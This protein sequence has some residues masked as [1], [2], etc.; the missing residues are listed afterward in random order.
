[1][2]RVVALLAVAALGAATPLGAQQVT[3]RVGGEPTSVGYGT[4]FTVPITVDMSAS[5]GQLL[6][7]YTARFTWNPSVLALFTFTCCGQTD[8]TLQGNFPPPAVN[9]D[10]VYAGIF[11]FSAVSPTGAGGLV[12]IAQLRLYNYDTIPTPLQLSFSEMSAAGTFTSLLPIL[13][14]QNATFCNARGRWGDLDR[15]G[16]SNSRDA[17]FVLSQVVGLAVNPLVADTSLADVD[18]D[19]RSTS[20]D[21][22][23][24]LSYA[25]GIPIPGH[26][27]LLP[28]ANSCG[29]G[30][31]RQLAVSPSAIDLA[32][33]QEF[34][35]VVQATD[36]AGR[37]VSAPPATWRSSDNTIA[38]VGTD[39]VVTPRGA[40][41]ATIT[42]E[43]APG[44]TA[45]ATVTVLARR[46]NWIV[47][48]AATGRPVQ[49][50]S[51]T[52]PYAHPLQAFPWV[53]EGDTI[54][55]A[56]GTYYW[57]TSG[58]VGVG[59][60][61]LGGTPGDT[62][63]RPIFRDPGTFS[64]GMRLA[65]GQRTVIRNV[66]FQNF[67]E[68]ID[69]E[70]VLGLA[71]E[72]TKFLYTG[73]AS[74]DAIYHCGASMDTVRIDRTEFIGDPQYRFGDAVYVSGCSPIA[75][76]VMLF[77][78]SRIQHMSDALYM[79]GVDSLVVLR[80]RITD[81]DGYGIY[82]SQEYS[83]TP[84]LYV[85]HSR[86]ER[87]RY[88]EI[89]GDYMRRV[90]IDTS[91]IRADT[92]EALNLGGDFNSRQARI[93]LHGDSIYDD[94][95]FY[96]WLTV[97]YADSLVMEDLVLRAPDDTSFATGGTVDADVA[98]VRRSRFLNLG[99][100]GSPVFQFS[101]R[102]LLADSVTMT[103]CAVSGCDNAYGFQATPGGG[104]QPRAQILRSSFSGIYVP[105][106]ASG[107]GLVLEVRNVTVDSAY[108]GVYAYNLDSALVAQSTFTRITSGGVVLSA[109]TGA[110][111]P[112]LI[113]G[114]NITCVPPVTG[115]IMPTGID[116]SNSGA[117]AQQDT[118]TGCRTGIQWN[119]TTPASRVRLNALRQNR[120]GVVL[121]HFDTTVMRVDSNGISG[122]DTAAVFVNAGAGRAS[123]TH[124]RIENNPGDGFYL[125]FTGSVHQ[126][127][128][129]AFVNNAG[130]AV[131]A[132]SDSVDASANWWGAASAPLGS[133][134][135]GVS[136]R[137]NT[138]GFLTSAPPNLPSLA[139]PAMRPP[140]G[141][142][143]P[144]PAPAAAPSARPTGRDPEAIARERAA[145]REA[146]RRARD[147]RRAAHEARRQRP[148]AP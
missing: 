135:N 10:S 133:P 81:N 54:R 16:R 75:V 95:A 46:P 111:G 22:L 59:V 128:D 89:R 127:H 7:S 40:G 132:A 139:P 73:S 49:N 34:R 85:A 107:S 19:A 41:T 100:S 112:S 102:W 126:A 36:S 122:S 104:A 44:V 105:I 62:T 108:Q 27:V 83:E 2:T 15:D 66:V 138:T 64:T 88:F 121:S 42:A 56:T 97:D 69:L 29:T 99:G 117:V 57:D 33:G 109:T 146:E 101:S 25:V 82:M 3:A 141:S 39:G 9:T 93:Y 6:G 84:A 4:T 63:T 96:N 65:G 119:S 32:V 92:A 13:T 18:A 28:A 55:V 125:G 8:S 72:D 12:T 115:V 129:N 137:V 140:A 98:I 118:V 43:V 142:G 50:G 91:V 136:G 143:A 21:A 94:E 116:V 48:I 131:Q 79:Y 14:V 45:T 58:D 120:H 74:G 60:V 68:A 61:L 11:K 67:S 110:R 23:V 80:S 106:Q 1:M 26:R 70:G 20:R 35:F 103:G 114:N 53:A 51:A 113:A 148:R 24:I 124:N 76:R 144:A 86:V 5:G 38:A 147:E 77:R 130:F 30:S 87:N 47:D 90:V 31:A 78:D 37:A 17:L 123:L 71:V 52:Y 145:S 134:P